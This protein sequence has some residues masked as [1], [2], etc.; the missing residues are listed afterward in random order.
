MCACE[1]LNTYSS[2]NGVHFIQ[3]LYTSWFI[4]VQLQ[5]LEFFISSFSLFLVKTIMCN[6]YSFPI[7][8]ERTK[9]ISAVIFPLDWF[10]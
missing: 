3:A 8:I 1:W 2:S 10:W 5:V 4:A 6:V 7:G 9:I